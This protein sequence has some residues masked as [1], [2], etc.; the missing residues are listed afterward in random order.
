MS[1]GINRSGV[2]LC[3]LSTT[4]PPWPLLERRLP[5][6]ESNTPLLAEGLK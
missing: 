3:R 2:R 5:G 4:S 6:I 1:F